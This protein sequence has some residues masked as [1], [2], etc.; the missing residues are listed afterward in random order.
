VVVEDEEGGILV[1]VNGGGLLECNSIQKL[2][3]AG[4]ALLELGPGH[5][6]RTQVRTTGDD[7]VLVASGDPTLTGDDLA[8]LGA[9]AARAGIRKVQSVV[10]DDSR[11]D[12]ERSVPGWKDYYMPGFTGPLSAFVLDRNRWRRDDGY[13]ADPVAAN[14]ARVVDALREAGV[15]VESGW[16]IGGAP[17]DDAAVVAEHVSAPLADLVRDMVLASDTFAAELLTK[18]L[19]A[20]QGAGTTAAGLAVIEDVAARLGLPRAPGALTADGSGLAAATTDTAARQVAWLRAMDESP[21]ADA[22][23]RC[24]P[25]AAESGTLA[26]RFRGTPAAGRV[27]AKT[28]TR[29]LHGT[30]NLAGYAATRSGRHLRFAITL[31]GADSLA[32]AQAAVDAAVVALADQ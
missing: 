24:L 8:A 13:V 15:V 12:R 21:A 4:A 27:H 14:A 25:V 11:Y 32:D 30:V 26:M 28:G 18:E 6:F 23:R 31:T 7:L 5:R 19:G 1:D 17:R 3:T 22:F 16:R 29:R 2:F 9:A 10:I 20:R